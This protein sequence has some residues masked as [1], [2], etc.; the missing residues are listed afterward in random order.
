MYVVV[1]HLSIYRRPN[2]LLHTHYYTHDYIHINTDVYNTIEDI[3]DMQSPLL[4]VVRS[5]V[6]VRTVGFYVCVISG[7][8]TH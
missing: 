2:I 6:Y 1:R 7:H 4:T 3:Y 8:H 5:D